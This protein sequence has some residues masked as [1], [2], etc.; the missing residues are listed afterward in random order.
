MAVFLELEWNRSLESNF[1][2]KNDA[3][4]NCEFDVTTLA[5]KLKSLEY[6]IWKSFG[7]GV[8]FIGAGVDKLLRS[9][10]TGK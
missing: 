2:I 4:V 7:V 5:A 10:L 3:S 1:K 8:E 6:D 9:T